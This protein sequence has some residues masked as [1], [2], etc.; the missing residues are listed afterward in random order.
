[1]ND[2][3]VALAGDPSVS[4]ASRRFYG[5]VHVV[6]GLFFRLWVRIDIQG[7][8]HVPVSGGFVLA[9]GAHRSI[10]DT[11]V[12]GGT[13][14]RMLRYMGAE[15]YFSIPVLGWFLRS[16]GGFPVERDATDRAALRLAQSLLEAGEP[17][18]VFPEGTRFSGPTVEPLKEGAA[19]LACRANVPIVPVGI[20][21]AERA[22]P[23]GGKF[24]RPSKM[25]LVV[26]PP[27]Y[28]PEREEGARI[29]RSQ[30]TSMTAD[31]HVELQRLFD[32][33]QTRAG[34]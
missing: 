28:P 14:K 15:T 20:G 19:F 21:G 1:M 23:K 22:W 26:G 16:V 11:G 8:E 32:Q 29:K 18:V 5:V 2:S 31:L 13:T 12:I 4:A 9:P 30:I 3:A 27:L 34:A 25:A 17:L 7:T 33:A 24:I 6:F 10:I